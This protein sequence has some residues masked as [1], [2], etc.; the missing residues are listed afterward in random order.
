MIV[1]WAAAAFGGAW[2]KEAGE[3]YL[4]AGGDVWSALRYVAP[5]ETEPSEGSYFGQQY[6]LYGEIG[7]IPDRKAQL[8]LSL[9][10]VLGTHHA[11]YDDAFG[12]V[13][14]RASTIRAGDLR[15]AAQIA[16][17]PRLPLALS[18]DLKIPGYA[19]GGI[20]DDH[21]VYRNLFPKP[22]D[23]QVDVGAM[24]YVGATSFSGGFA[25]LG[26]GFVHR[27]EAFVGWEPGL[28]FSDG[29][30]FTAK[31]GHALGRV[32]PILSTEGT[33]SP[34]PTRYTRSFVSVALSASIDVGSGL[35]IEPRLA[36][37]VWARRTSR[38]IGGG[39]GLSYRR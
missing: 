20:G 13:E 36:G 19:N 6:G 31:A 29:L 17:H 33:L 25:E 9:P 18:V 28:G 24:A 30:R 27:T 12:S 22:G 39:I 4:K 35:A 23:G 5:G 21:P 16:L 3:A 11:V 10:L 38:G 14:V 15:L 7:V 34:A 8:S 37:E 26:V 32:L 2:T 1:W